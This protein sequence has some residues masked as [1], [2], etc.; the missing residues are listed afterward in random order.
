M[1]VVPGDS[2]GDR[3]LGGLYM[4]RQPYKTDS[5]FNNLNYGLRSNRFNSGK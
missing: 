2:L 5:I 3:I 1:R 4:P